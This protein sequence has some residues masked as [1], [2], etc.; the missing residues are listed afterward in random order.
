MRTRF[1][2]TGLCALA[3]AA[4]CS[5]RASAAGAAP[6]NEAALEAARG[7]SESNGGQAMV[8]MLD[9]KTIDA[10]DAPM[11]TSTTAPADTK[12]QWVLP[13]VN[14]PRVQ[15]RTFDSAAVKT[16]V[17][18]FIYTP[19]I[20][21][22]E[23]EMR[24]P[25]LYWLHGSGGG[26]AGV[27]PLAAH[28]DSAIRA[29][30]IA[31]MLVVFANGLPDGMWCDW[32]DG[33]MPMETIV[34]KE[35]VPHIDA[36]FRTIAKREGRVIE[37]FSMGGYGAARLGFKHHG[38]FGAVSI[39]GAGPLH[40]EFQTVRVGPRGRDWILQTVFG[41]DLEYF[42]AQSPWVLAE[43]NAAAVRGKTRIR[44]A[45]GDRDETLGFNRDFHEHL[46]KLEIPH[47]FTVLPGIPHNPM[48]VLDAL[49]EANWEFYR[50]VFGKL[51]PSHRTLPPPPDAKPSTAADPASPVCYDPAKGGRA[52]ILNAQPVEPF[53]IMDGLFYVGNTQVSAH[54]LKTANG[55]VLMDS[56]MPHQ[57]AW[58]LESL[59]KL[60]FQPRDVKVVIGTH[61]AVD[62]TGNHWYLQ[63]YFGAQIWLHELDAPAA[64]AAGAKPDLTRGPT[65]EDYPPFK[66]DR[67]VKDNETIEW[68]GRTLVFYHTPISTP[69]AIT[70]EIPLRDPSGK[71]LRAAMVGGQAPRMPDIP[72][73]VQR[74]K[75]LDVQVWLAVHPSQNHTLEKAARLKGSGAATPFI[76]PE[77]WKTFLDRL[78][79]AGSRGQRPFTRTPQKP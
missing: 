19:E 12:S 55:L 37:G 10:Q 58:L 20:Y 78:G 22:T 42:K 38:V 65:F 50:A 8:A 74:L 48:G 66:P 61:A 30:K 1:Q 62:H 44:Q 14:A 15:H 79:S 53:E 69:G 45:I 13:A 29:S 3:L 46:A 63:R 72:V 64:L 5:C 76:D 57:T 36:T 16:K 35:L 59:R 4:I 25:V 9:G 73:V 11:Q 18:Y 77:G 51:D 39:L 41:G 32:K 49:G 68:G 24:F 28:F 67:L 17:S 70:I 43:Q 75:T 60:S 2:L 31:P 27:P 56:T 54:L 21:D 71:P 33:S 6:P 40:P 47:S 52:A 26:S 7:C 34:M 23:K